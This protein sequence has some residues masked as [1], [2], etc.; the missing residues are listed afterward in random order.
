[1]CEQEKFRALC[2]LHEQGV[3]LLEAALFPLGGKP[4]QGIFAHAFE[5]F[6]LP[7]Q[8]VQFHEDSL[9]IPDNKSKC[10]GLTQVKD[11]A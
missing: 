4:G 1:M 10:N 11:F 5:E 3:P 2:P 7:E 9:L 6:G 8:V